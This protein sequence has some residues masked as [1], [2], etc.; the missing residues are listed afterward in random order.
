MRTAKWIPLLFAVASLY[1]GLLGVSFLA[2]PLYLFELFKVPPPNHV[3]YVQ[4]SAA[5]LLI[6]ALM[7]IQIARDP[8]T[9]RRLIA[10]GI[11]LKVAYC[12]V[13]GG[14]W[15]AAGIPGMWKPFVMID[16]AMG[17][18]FAWAYLVLFRPVATTP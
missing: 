7:F 12:S 2:A 8:I 11:L 9:N 13:V 16:L 5:L 15:L 14:H 17:L 3:G 18:L 6:F 1:D 10:Y 4:F